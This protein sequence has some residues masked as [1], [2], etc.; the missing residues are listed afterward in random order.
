MTSTLDISALLLI[1]IN[2][3]QMV[4][5]FFLLLPIVE[6]T[7]LSKYIK[8]Y[9]EVIKS[10]PWIKI[11]S[12]FYVIIIG[13]YGIINPTRTFN[14]LKISKIL[15]YA[16]SPEEK[17]ESVIYTT[18]ATRNYLLAGFSLFFVLVTWRLFD[19]IAFSAKLHEFSNLMGNY[20]L[21]DITFTIETEKEEDTPLVFDEII[22]DEDSVHWPS[23]A[24]LNQIELSRIQTFFKET[25]KTAEL[26]TD[27]KETTAKPHS[28]NIQ[29]EDDDT[30]HSESEDNHRAE[31]H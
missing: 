31:E 17:L 4:S 13:G 6:I 30:Q 24:N 2:I 29:S 20:N 11:F 27:N 8:R 26:P 9:R 5:I 15:T 7:T 25:Y 1:S 12:I 19:Y 28:I 3:I 16:E 23:I 14:R 22:E 10:N 21:I 18:I